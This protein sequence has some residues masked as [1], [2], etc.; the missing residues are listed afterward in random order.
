MNIAVDQSWQKMRFNYVAPLQR[1]LDAFWTW[2]ITELTSLLPPNLQSALSQRDQRDFVEF[3]GDAFIVRRGTMSGNRELSRIP[4]TVA[5][6]SAIESPADAK[7]TVLLLPADKVLVKSMTLPLAAEENLREVL[8]FEMDRQTPFTADQVYYDSIVT[9]RN[10]RRKTLS[11]DLVLAPRTVV[12]GLLEELANS[13]L[14]A[15]ILSTRDSSGTA[16]LPINLLPRRKRG[17]RN[18]AVRRLNATLVVVTVL[19]FIT[20]IA[21]PLLQKQQVLGELEPQLIAAVAQAESANELRQQ[22]ARLMAGSGDLVRKKQTGLSVLR[23]INELTR[24]LPDHTWINRLDIS[25]T[26]V[27]LQGQSSSSAMLISLLEG[28]PVLKNVR[29][30]S[31]VIRIPSTGE[32]RF[33][34]SAEIEQE[35][36]Q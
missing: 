21:L 13:G 19:L 3:D 26:E 34:L 15:D 12:D 11:V 6:R 30:R 5:E 10:T 4:R 23:T 33:H 2:W 22:V 14:R 27:Q 17:N 29:F 20:V 16:M 36:S 1:Q 9:S 8:S 18:T 7:E 28:S 25:E 24:V 35:Q 31:P 32:E